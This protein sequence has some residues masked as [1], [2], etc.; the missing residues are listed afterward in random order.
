MRWVSGIAAVWMVLAAI[1]PG[2]AAQGIEFA[3]AFGPFTVPSGLGMTS[4]TGGT[5]GGLSV[6]LSMM[7]GSGSGC[8]SGGSC[9]TFTT[10]VA[11]L[12][13][14]ASA[15]FGQLSG[16]F[17]CSSGG[18]TFTITGATG[19]FS[20][21]TG[22]ALSLSSTGPTSTMLGTSFPNHG[23]YVSE[24]ARSAAK[25]KAQGLMPADMTVGDIVS[26]A[27]HNQKELQQVSQQ[28]GQ[29]IGTGSEASGGN[30]GGQGNGTGN[31]NGK[32]NEN[33]NGSGGNGNGGGN[34]HGEGNGD[35][36]GKGRGH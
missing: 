8:P 28:G 21:V 5:V 6:T 30:A 15:Q 27:A 13:T 34:G 35:G 31:G 25:L 9:G 23:A 26:Q 10:S 20:R 19:V 4:Q 24:V 12:G 7:S 18:C 16:T 11:G 29:E 33:G 22:T 2:W 1:V 14:I 32:S 36:G 17:A 3:V